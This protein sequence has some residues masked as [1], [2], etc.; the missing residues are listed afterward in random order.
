MAQKRRA[1]ETGGCVDLVIYNWTTSQVQSFLRKL[2]LERWEPIFEDIDGPTLT[3]LD[4]ADLKELGCENLVMRKKLLGHVMKLKLEAKSANDVALPASGNSQAPETV[5]F[6][7]LCD[8]PA[9]SASVPESASDVPMESQQTHQDMTLAELHTEWE[10][11]K[12]LR[13]EFQQAASIFEKLLDQHVQQ[14]FGEQNLARNFAQEVLRQIQ[15]AQEVALPSPARIPVFGNTGAGKS[16]LLNAVLRQN[17]VPTSG[18][19]SCT[20]VPVELTAADVPVFKGEVHLKSMD[21]WKGEVQAALQ[22]LLM[23]DRQR[24]SRREPV[25]GKEETPADVAFATLVAVYPQA[26]LYARDPWPSVTAAM[27][28]LFHIRN[29]VTIKHAADK[30]LT[31][32]NADG[33]TLAQE[34]VDY[35]D[36]PE[37]DWEPAFFPLVKKVRIVC[38]AGAM[39]PHVI[40]VDAPGV[41]DANAARG[42]VVKKLLEDANSVVIVSNIKRAATERVAQEMLSERFRRQLLMDGHYGRLAFVAS[43]T[44]EL[45]LSELKRNLKLKGDVPK[46][47]AA[48]LRNASAKEKITADCFAGLRRIEI[49]SEQRSQSTDEDFRRRGIAPAVFTTSARDYQKLS[50]LLD[51]TVDGGP[52]VWSTLRDTEIPDFRRWIHAQGQKAQL[53]A[54]EKAEDQFSSACR[55]LQ[56]PERQIETVPTWDPSTMSTALRKIKE[57][58]AAIMRT[59]LSDKL[60][61]SVGIGQRTAAEEGARNMTVR[62][63]GQGAGGLHWGTF[64]ATCRRQGEWREDF[65]ELLADPLNRRIAVEWDRVLNQL[66]PDHVDNLLRRIVDEIWKLQRGMD[67]PLE[68]FQDAEE[69]VKRRGPVLK[70]NLQRQQ[71]E[72]SRQIKETIKQLMTPSYGEAA[73]VSGTGTDV[74]QKAIIRNQVTERGVSMFRKASDFLGGE[75]DKLLSCLEQGLEDLV[76]ALTSVLKASMQ[77]L[78]AVG[79]ERQALRALQQGCGAAV[80]QALQKSQERQRRRHAL[81]YSAVEVEV[82]SKPRPKSEANQTSSKAPM[83]SEYFCPISQEVMVDPVTTSDGHTYDRKPIEEWLRNNDTSPNTGGLDCERRLDRD[84]AGQH[85]LRHGGGRSIA[86]RRRARGGGSA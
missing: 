17:V 11:L 61:S 77:R 14:G 81:E 60:K 74:R 85:D 8:V 39:H 58:Q 57:S 37:R 76:E 45:T 52:Q 50:G 26:F 31:F 35:I 72:V 86:T 2:Q 55:K 53:D 24:V 49:Q 13:E 20:A 75:L 65:N 23:S 27:N 34:V 18:W 83:P 56:E 46:E 25:R 19:R 82:A 10:Q 59:L 30:V 43:C 21:E 84:G 62:C 71:M 29:A 73:S 48:A 6:L 16:T 5:E 42:N 66:L 69:L 41:Q 38:P 40:L 33:E 28:E 15:E 80:R 47:K 22:D 70:G 63:Q 3:E 7:A 79:T 51:M 12:Q 68:P 36:S 9:A 1:E 44:D 4:D 64:K 32:Q 54:L 67:L 78:A